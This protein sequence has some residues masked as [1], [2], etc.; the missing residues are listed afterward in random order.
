MKRIAISLPGDVA[1]VAE[2]EARRRRVSLA[3]LVRDAL[4]EHLRDPARRK[5]PF[6]GIFA[7]G[8][9][10]AAENFEEILAREWHPDR[11]R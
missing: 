8:D 5:L 6:A 3:E 1:L 10:D 9:T 7:S 4:V 2:R 11:D